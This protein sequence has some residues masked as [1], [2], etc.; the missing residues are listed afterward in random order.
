MERVPLLIISHVGDDTYCWGTN[1]PNS[2]VQIA[3]EGISMWGGIG[4]V[5]ASHQDA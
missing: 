1:R 4:F 3:G 2:H 5:K